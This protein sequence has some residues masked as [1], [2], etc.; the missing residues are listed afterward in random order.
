MRLR[1]AELV[2]AWSLATDLGLG[3]PQE[4]VLRQCRIALGL[5]ERLGLDEADR[6]AVYYVAMLAWVGCTADSHELAHQFG[7]D[8]ALRADAHRVD[9]A[10]RPMVGFLLRRVGAGRPPLRRAGMAAALVASGGRDAAE[11]MTAHCQVAA[12]IASAAGTRPRGA[13]AAAACLLALGRDR[14]PRRDGRR[15]AAAG[16]QARPRRR[17]RRGPP[18]RRR[19]RRRDRGRTRPL[20]GTVRPAAGGGVHRLRPRAARRAGRGVELGRGDRGRAGPGQGARGRPARRRPR[21]GRRLRRPQV[22]LVHGPLARRRAARRRGSAGGGA[23]RRRGHG[24]AARRAP[25]RPGAD[26]GAEHDL[27]QARTADRGR[28]RAGAAASL[29]HRAHARA[30]GGAGRTRER[31][32]PAT[33]SAWTA[34]AITARCRGPLCRL[35]RGCWP[36]RTP[37][38]R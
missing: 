23:A 6:A 10:G 20:R 13:G 4:H 36:R 17:D 2:A 3:L 7:D 16:D 9:L 15:G 8:L 14:G 37:T 1:L 25:P 31:S 32:R 12:A 27:G 33:T 35:P 34:R 38:T 5:A 22:A 26:R 28:A 30:P 24:A 11:A 29:L 18:P 19:R 21:G